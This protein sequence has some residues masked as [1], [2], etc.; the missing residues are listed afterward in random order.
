MPG[1][2]RGSQTYYAAFL[3]LYDA[4]SFG[5]ELLGAAKIA[6]APGAKAGLHELC[7]VI[8]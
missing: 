4:P 5:D 1:N 2:P 8:G 6:F 7:R 3:L